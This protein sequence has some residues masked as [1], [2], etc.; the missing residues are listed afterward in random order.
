MR[1]TP[2]QRLAL[3]ASAAALLLGAA[4]V[5]PAQP[6]PQSDPV[7]D[8]FLAKA[9]RTAPNREPAIAHPAQ[10]KA[11]AAKL[12]QL[13]AR[14]G[15][16]PNIVVI[17]LD[18]VGWGDFGVFGGGAAVGA[19]TPNI[20]RLA[21]S[22]LR[23]TSAYSQPSCTPTRS[24]LLTGRL[25]VRTGLLT[26]LLP[27]ENNKAAGLNGEVTLAALL[28]Q[29]GYRTQA[30]GKWHIGGSFGAQPQ[31][32][33][34]ANYYGILTSSDDYTAFAEPWRNPDIA[35]DPVRRAWAEGE[36]TMAIVEGDTGTEARPVFP[37]NRDSIRFVDEKLT[38]R[39]TRFIAAQ[40]K[41]K[42]PFFLY[43][44]TR[45]AHNDNYPHPDFAG[46]SPAK[47][48]YK[49]VMVEL[50]HRIGQLVQAL[51][52]NGVAEN[53]LV[54]LASDNG[55]FAEAFPDTGATP[56]RGAKGTAYEGGVRSPVIASWPGVIAPGRVSDGLFDLMDIFPTSLTLSG[57][58]E[59]VPSDR[60]IDGV[61]QSGF[62]LSDTG[63]SARRAVYYWVNTI[64]MG[65]RVGEFKFLRRDQKFEFDDTW[66]RASPFQSSV[67]EPAYGGK[68]FD[69]YIDPKE[70]HALLP[71]KQPQIPVMAQA[72]QAHLATFKQY[73]P[74]MPIK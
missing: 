59:L 14:F 67:S 47:Y 23:L 33:G 73:P 8:P 21:Q 1:M 65:A 6:A 40:A 5:A 49:D 13:R 52:A 61:D 22:G 63:Q 64:F 37:L 34:F 39:A 69:L 50:D 27:G 62:L 12:A 32:N 72:V 46:K 71:L 28:K 70:E 55:P 4:S 11:A 41:A 16:A 54:I 66:P 20:D 30:I 60:Y 29:A 7:V 17:L 36:E 56:F 35:N 31:N 10:A 19:P 9:V 3:A 45:G 51:K 2:K 57:N 58:A 44:A 18:D 43:F 42:A 26:P 38:E 53:T 24:S 15:H 74:K 25:P 48:P 68:L